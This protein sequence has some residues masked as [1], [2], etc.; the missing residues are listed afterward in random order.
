MSCRTTPVHS[1]RAATRHRRSS[2][3]RPTPSSTRPRSRWKRSWTIATRTAATSTWPAGRATPRRT[4]PGSLRPTLTTKRPSP[5]I[6]VA[7]ARPPHPTVHLGGSDV[8]F[9]HHINQSTVHSRLAM[10]SR[11]R[12]R[13]PCAEFFPY[14]VS[15]SRLCPSLLI[16]SSDSASASASQF[17]FL[18][19]YLS[20]AR[21]SLV[22]TSLTIVPLATSGLPI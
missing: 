9:P 20:A 3:S 4:T 10:Q 15:G 8:V 11:L 18:L 6:G 13:F 17:L 7:E 14:M 21:P 5:A 22:A 12:I 1:S 19:L 2:S 16:I